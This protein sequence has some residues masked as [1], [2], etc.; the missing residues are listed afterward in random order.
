MYIN[1]GK[2]HGYIL[3]SLFYNLQWYLKENYLLK[4]Q[5]CHKFVLIHCDFKLDS[6]Y[7]ESF[8]CALWD[9]DMLYYILNHH[10]CY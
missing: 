8:D 5:K 3:V 10:H 6:V 1:D 2:T 9:G 7:K 4:Q